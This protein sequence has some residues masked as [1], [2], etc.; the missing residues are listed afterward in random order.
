MGDT[1]WMEDDPRVEWKKVNPYYNRLFPGL[2]RPDLGHK[3]RLFDSQ[4]QE[5]IYEKAQ[6][7]LTDTGSQYL[8]PTW[9]QNIIRTKLE[10]P[11]TQIQ[12][13]LN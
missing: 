13:S 5:F 1:F 9:R 6:Y 4:I 3:S 11:D 10:P 2:G 12:I 7:W 8:D